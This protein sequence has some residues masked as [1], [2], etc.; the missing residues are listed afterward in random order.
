MMTNAALD[1]R[2][3]VVFLAAAGVVLPFM[4]RLRISPIIGFVGIGL[5]LGPG[6]LG[7]F[8]GMVPGI[9]FL[10]IT[11]RAGIAVLSE[12]GL[13]FLLFMIGLE[14]S[15][16]RLWAMRVRVFGM[17]GAQ[18]VA[19]ATVMIVLLLTA[20]LPLPAA[21]VIGSALSMSST[22]IVMQILAERGAVGGRLGRSALAV[23]LFQDLAVIPILLMTQ[24]FGDR[25]GQPVVLDLAFAAIKAAIAVAVILALGRLLL[26]PLFRMVIATGIRELFLALVL[27]TA[28]GTAVLTETIGLSLALG[29]FLAGLLVSETEYRHQIAVDIEPVKGLLLGVFFVSVGL[30]IDLD[31]VVAAPFLHLGA[32]IGFLVIKAT[33]LLA[34][35]LAIGLPKSLMAELSLLLA[36][37]S[38]FVFVVVGIA[39]GFGLITTEASSLIV[40]VVGL[41]MLSA[42]TVGVIT[43]RVVPHLLR[44][45]K[46]V[47]DLPPEEEDGHVVVAGYGRVGRAVGGALRE[48]GIPIAAVDSDALIVGA[49][50]KTGVAIHW[51]NAIHRPLLKRLGT[52]RAAALVVTMNDTAAAADVVRVAR[53]EWPDLPIF[54]RAHDTQHARLLLES[55]AS[56][57]VLLPLEA[58]L[59]LAEAV[60][61]ATGVPDEVAHA[62]TGAER[63]RQLAA[64]LPPAVLG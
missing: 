52:G 37:G 29:A 28:I 45:E 10:L 30:G 3:M 20:G 38:E 55:G 8:S 9:D 33:V 62:I 4:H 36:G 25:S 11:D 22:A 39:G 6:G 19:T 53:A 18:M 2:E 64:L 49:L 35:C 1:L 47:P 44:N 15:L 21:I 14:L 5:L 12:L 16:D 63:D 61:S 34:V 40:V 57:V 24:A 59:Q 17:G 58:S 42:P 60:L 26:R 23:L 27:V 54:A 50:R 56:K 48:A 51:G 32:L 46:P 7:R 31:R 43:R 41:S 13:V